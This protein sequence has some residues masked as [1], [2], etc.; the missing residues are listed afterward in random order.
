[1]HFPINEHLARI[2]KVAIPVRIKP[3]EQRVVARIHI[4]AI[5]MVLNDS[6]DLSRG[7]I[8]DA[9]AKNSII[10]KKESNHS[11]NFLGHKVLL[12]R[13]RG[14]ICDQYTQQEDHL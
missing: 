7:P 10:A 4:I 1:M 12:R 6:E 11:V 9:I 8:V 14:Q 3:I 2:V 13:L 5:K